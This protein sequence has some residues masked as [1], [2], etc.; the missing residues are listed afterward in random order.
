MANTLKLH[1]NGASLLAKAFGV[2]FIVWLGLRLWAC[3]ATVTYRR[4]FNDGDISSVF[5][6]LI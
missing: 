3:L 4:P 1:R 6:Y 5:S 2:G